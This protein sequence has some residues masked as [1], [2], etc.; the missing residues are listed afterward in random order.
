MPLAAGAAA[1]V[2]NLARKRHGFRRVT[3]GFGPVVVLA[4]TA[5]QGRLACIFAVHE[6]AG[7]TPA[8]GLDQ[9]VVDGGGRCDPFVV[10]AGQAGGLVEPGPHDKGAGEGEDGWVSE[11][12]DKGF[13]ESTGGGGGGGRGMTTG[14]VVG[15]EFSEDHVEGAGDGEKGQV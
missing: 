12:G 2:D 9:P 13:G 4:H 3:P 1:H 11:A 7:P 6:G 5:Q 14:F 10:G 15:P 8:E